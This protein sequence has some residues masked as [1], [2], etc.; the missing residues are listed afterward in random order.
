MIFNSVWLTEWSTDPRA[1]D[2]DTT[3]R[4]IYMGVYGGLGAAQGELT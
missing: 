3:W 2:E 4:N 1:M